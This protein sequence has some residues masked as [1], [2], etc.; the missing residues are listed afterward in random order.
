MIIKII[1]MRTRTTTIIIII[2]IIMM[3]MMMMITIMCIEFL[4]CNSDIVKTETFILK[5]CHK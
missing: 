3:M 1:I 4:H 2:I 5:C